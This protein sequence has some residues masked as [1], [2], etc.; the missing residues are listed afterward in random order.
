MGSMFFAV[1]LLYHDDN[2]FETFETDFSCRGFLIRDGRIAAQCK[3]KV[4]VSSK[5]CSA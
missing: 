1:G 3:L 2:T 4:L 5:V